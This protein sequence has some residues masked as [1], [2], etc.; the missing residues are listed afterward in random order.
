MIQAEC[1]HPKT[2]QNN[3]GFSNKKCSDWNILKYVKVVYTSVHICTSNLI[4]VHFYYKVCLPQL[5][6]SGLQCEY[7]D[8]SVQCVYSDQSVQCTE[9]GVE[10]TV[11][12]LGHWIIAHVIKTN[13]E[14]RVIL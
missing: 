14:I 6:N 9:T 12:H 8:Q 3:E 10:C 1:V 11:K 7:S 5:C 4:S 13:S 2:Q